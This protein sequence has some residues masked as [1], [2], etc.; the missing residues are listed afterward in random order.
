MRIYLDNCVFQYL[1]KEEYS[2]L[3][4]TILADKQDNIYC[5]SEAHV[6]DLSRDQSQQK[7]DD[8]RFIES[9]TENHCFYFD[10]DILFKYLTP[11]EY[12]ES[13]DWTTSTSA[14]SF[15]SEP[16]GFIGMIKLLFQSIPLN[17]GELIPLDQL[18]PDMPD[19]FR[20]ML[21]G[22]VT[23]YDFMEAMGDFTDQLTEEKQKFK[24]F[25]QYLHRNRLIQ[26]I[27][28]QMGILGYDGT[29]V[30]DME[31]FSE[32]YQKYFSQGGNSK[33]K[34]TLFTNM[35]HGLE[36]F[37]FVKSKPKK[38]RMMNMINDARHAFFGACCDVVISSDV[39]FLNKTKFLYS[40]LGIQTMVLDVS[41]AE[42]FYKQSKADAELNLVELLQD[43][44]KR[45][46]SERVI[47]TYK[48]EN[49]ELTGYKLTATYFSYFDIL[50]HVT[51][52]SH[53]HYYYTKSSNSLLGG[54][55]TKELAY[56]TNTL[57][58]QL[59]KDIYERD[60]FS[61]SEIVDG[62]WHGRSWRI[63]ETLVQLNYGEEG[64]RLHLLF[65]PI[66]HLENNPQSKH[67]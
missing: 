33:T 35:Y 10:K 43:S 7:F 46:L 52:S 31:K 42:T 50:V 28:E 8:M 18:P 64:N 36:L 45:G 40:V 66:E 53:T 47:E 60:T 51:S 2:G 20:E 44:R 63:G 1:K 27:Y 15:L 32:S 14:K 4:S 22:S 23:M 62:K 55:L 39:D 9:I 13:Y 30:T 41:E 11:I 48:E 65:Y 12:Y 56:V 67:P 59:G 34:Y 21:T 24:E 57:C 25:I 19:A 29:M 17:L 16:D 38:Q 5:F 54:I 3:L 61:F 49:E 37:G 58:K 26:E 6:F